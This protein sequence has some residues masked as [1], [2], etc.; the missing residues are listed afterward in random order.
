MFAAGK[1]VPQACRN[2][3]ESEQIAS[4]YVPYGSREDSNVEV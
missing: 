4:V 2:I 1:S 3:G